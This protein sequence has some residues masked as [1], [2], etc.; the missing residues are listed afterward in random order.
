MTTRVSLAQYPRRG[1]LARL[2]HFLL[3]AYGSTETH[4]QRCVVIDPAVSEPTV[5]LAPG[6]HVDRRSN[7]LALV[8][9]SLTHL[10]ADLAA[11]H[12]QMESGWWVLREWPRA[13]R[14]RGVLH[15]HGLREVATITETTRA[16][17]PRAA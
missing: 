6:T 3:A 10:T 8:L 16:A 12:T 1:N 2:E 11:E 7:R 13:V 17:G 14:A 5:L 9:P 4:Y 15:G